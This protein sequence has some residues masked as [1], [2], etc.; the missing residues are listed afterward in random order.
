MN[1]PVVVAVTSDQHTNSQLGLCPVEGVTLDEGGEYHPSI[2]QRWLWDNWL[3]YHAKIAE[4][5]REL[6]AK[7]IYVSNGDAF[8]GD[9]HGTSQIIS[10]NVESQAYI[11]HQ[12]FAVP[13]ALKADRYYVVRGTTVHVGEGG[14][15]EEALAKHLGCARDPVRNMR[16]QWH[17]RLQIHGVELDFQHHCS[18]GGLPWTR[19]AALARLAFRHWV[20]RTKRNL[21]PAS[22]LVRSHVHLHGDSYGAHKTR[23]IVTPA[24]Q[25]KTSH[26]HKVAPDSIADVG[27][28]AIVIWPDGRYEVRD[29][30]YEPS[31]PEP[32][33]IA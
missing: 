2:A 22:L 4:L 25:L 9:H 30:L 13:K 26:A 10:R 23:A 28:I 21:K 20:E 11:A 7:L 14:A 1:R 33:V 8:D 6:K 3:D 5:R 31:L 32:C 24:W 15:S 27:G 17:L 19:A 18:V 12:V 16:S 29:Y